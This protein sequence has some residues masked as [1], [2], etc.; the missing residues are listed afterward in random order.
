[1]FLYLKIEER[2]PILEPKKKIIIIIIIK[3]MIKENKD[4]HPLKLRC[5]LV[6]KFYFSLLDF[7]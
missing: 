7:V 6:W 5:P 1:M 4:I 3:T 2:C